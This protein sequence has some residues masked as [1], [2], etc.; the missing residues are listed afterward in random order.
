MTK[1]TEKVKVLSRDEILQT[2]DATTETIFVPEWGG[3]VFVKTLSAEE[4][5]EFENLFINDDGKR[6][7]QTE[8]TNLRAF[9]VSLSVVNENGERVFTTDDVEELNRKNANCIE[10]IFNVAQRLSALR[11]QD[12]KALT[13]NSETTQGADSISD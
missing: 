2:L 13:K 7:P 11:E 4:R 10:R 3:S 12:I 6:K 1:K 8:I 5:E 9:L